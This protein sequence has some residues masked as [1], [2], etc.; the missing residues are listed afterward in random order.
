GRL[1][2]KLVDAL[3]PLVLSSRPGRPPVSGRL[4]EGAAGLPPD[5]QPEDPDDPSSPEERRL[6]VVAT[7]PALSL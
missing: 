7:R 4:E 6:T 3:E 1:S 5:T 2:A